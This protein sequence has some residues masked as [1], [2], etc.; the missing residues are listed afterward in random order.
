MSRSAEVRRLRRE[1]QQQRQSATFVGQS[2][3]QQPPMGQQQW[4]NPMLQMGLMNPLIGKTNPMYQNQPQTSVIDAALAE[5]EQYQQQQAASAIVPKNA[6]PIHGN[7]TTFN[8][9][10][11]L[12]ENIKSSRYFQT[13]LEFNTVEDLFQEITDRVKSVEPLATGA[14][15]DPSTAFCILYRLFCIRLSYKDMNAMLKYKHSPYVPALGL[16]Y[17]RYVVE[18]KSIWEW[19]EPLVSSSIKFCAYGPGESVTLGEF[20]RELFSGNNYHGTITPRIPMAVA[21]DL[22]VKFL[23]LDKIAERAEKNKK[24]AHLLKP[25]MEMKAMYTEDNTWYQAKITAIENGE[26]WVSY[27]EYGNEEKVPLGRIEVPKDLKDK[28]RGDISSSSD[29]RKSRDREGGRDQ[30]RDHRKTGSRDYRDHSDRDRSSR[31][32]GD[33]RR[34]RDNRD[35]RDRDRDSRR[36]RSSRSRSASRRSDRRSRGRSHHKD[37]RDARSRSRSDS[38]VG[39]EDLAAEV[40]RMEQAKVVASGRDY[41]TRPQSFKAS[42]SMKLDRY[43][44]TKRI[45]SRSPEVISRP[46]RRR[47]SRSRSRSSDRKNHRGDVKKK[48][49][50]EMLERREKLRKA[51]GSSGS[52]SSSKGKGDLDSAYVKLG[53]SSH[54]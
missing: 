43:T 39:A 11:L 37:N 12:L 38:P 22:K 52:S 34:S 1:W 7:T 5:V 46:S 10:A 18:P 48:V 2:Q 44:K 42:L 16:I 54:W 6:I 8:I 40:L 9:N 25:G 45:R 35:N 21:R 14:S 53:G 13:L 28:L 3:T 36:R 19:I 41:A 26:Y 23:L 29:D 30:D 49:T 17:L 33:S 31:R 32:S 4:T 24:Y 50:A 51:Y 27:I 47:R 20:A 15:R